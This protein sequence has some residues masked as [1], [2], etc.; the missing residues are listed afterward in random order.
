MAEKTERTPTKDFLVPIE[1]RR[2][3]KQSKTQPTMSP[4]DHS[5]GN[6]PITGKFSPPVVQT[7]KQK[8]MLHE[9]IQKSQRLPLPPRTAGELPQA[10]EH[11]QG[12]KRNLLKTFENSEPTKGT[13][14]IINK[15]K[16]GINTSNSKQAWQ[17]EVKEIRK[18]Q[19]G[20]EVVNEPVAQVDL[21]EFPSLPA[22]DTAGVNG[23]ATVGEDDKQSK[24]QATNKGNKD[25]EMGKQD[26]D[27][28]EASRHSWGSCKET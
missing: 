1:A 18:V 21:Q 12:P 13:K 9:P 3:Y 7:P 8:K 6:S 10:Q 17:Q 15:A 11:S 20:K 4:A 19:D 23:G 2:V 22:K 14:P 24:D 25:V 5:V 27:G 16:E 26:S 28:D